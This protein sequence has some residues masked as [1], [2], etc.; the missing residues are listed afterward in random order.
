MGNQHIT[1]KNGFRLHSKIPKLGFLFAEV[2]NFDKKTREI[3]SNSILEMMIAAVISLKILT[4]S[5]NIVYGK[6]EIQ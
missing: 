4:N 2:S 1:I 5:D 6:L 3:I